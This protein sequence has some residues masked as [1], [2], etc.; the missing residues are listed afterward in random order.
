[1]SE[2]FRTHFVVNPNSANRLTGRVWPEIQKAAKDVIGDFEFSMTTGPMHAVELTREAIKKGAEMIVSVGGDGTNNEVVNG[3]FEDKKLIN[4]ETVLGIICSGTGSDFIR[5]AMIPRDFR[6]SVKLLAGKKT[7]PLDLGEMTFMDHD[8]RE[9]HRYFLNI[10]SFGVG[11]E[12][13]ELVNKTTK[14]LGG[15]AS[16]LYSSARATLAYKNK[17]IKIKI[18]DRIEIERKVFNAAVANGQFHGA[19]MRTAPK[20]CLD[21]SIFQ[22]VVIGDFSFFEALKMSRLIYDG[23]HVSMEK[24]ESYEGEKVTAT[25]DERVLLDVDGE[26]PGILPATFKIMP[27]VIQMKRP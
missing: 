24:V 4:P 2:H 9:A 21:D 26:Q 27:S 16:F 5:T 8:G 19:G 20:A 14:A 12:V 3:L 15:K 25:S 23:K 7:K 13:D 17:L 18:D 22:V 10:A 1:M 6:E 11:G